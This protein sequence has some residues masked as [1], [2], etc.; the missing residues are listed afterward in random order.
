VPYVVRAELAN[1]QEKQPGPLPDGLAELD[2]HVLRANGGRMKL[3]PRR[4]MQRTP[5]TVLR[6]VVALDIDGTLGYYHEHFL[7][8][9]E[10]W[11]QR[12]ELPTYWNGDEPFWR[13]LGT[14][15]TTYR[16]IKLC[17]RQGGMK[18]SMPVT[19]W[20]ANLTRHV[21]AAGAEVWVCTTRP[22]L[23]LDNIDPDTRFW[24]RHNRIQYDGVL[25]G[26]NKYRDLASLVGI[27]RVVAVLDDEPEQ[28]ARAEALELPTRIL[29]RAYNKNADSF[30][31]GSLLHAEKEFVELI[32]KWREERKV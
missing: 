7:S 4:A 2:R 25:F 5:D 29:D 30:R 32:G 21:R 31:C 26:E 17:Y 1:T 3:A 15:K 10:K 20:A 12:D 11:L 28:T 18:R 16:Q 8:F 19:P 6:P 13:L 22:Y 27:N 14:S 9:A 24:L 23:R